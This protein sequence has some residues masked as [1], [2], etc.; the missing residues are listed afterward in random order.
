MSQDVD[1]R[2]VVDPT[3]KI[4]RGC[5]LGPFCV[6]EAG[7]ELGEGCILEPFAR[8]CRNSTLGSGVRLG[9]GAVV[10][11]LPQVT[12]IERAGGC[13]I[14]DRTRLGEYATVHS[15]AD[16]DGCT[17][18]GPDAMVMAYAHV[19][20]D[21]SIGSAVVLANGVQLAGHVGIDRGSFVGGA[22]LVHQFV[23]VGEFAFVAGGIRLDRDLAPWSRA[24]GEPARWAGTNLVGL[25]RSTQA[26]D[27]AEASAALR[28]VFRK[29]LGLDQA[30]TILTN[31]GDDASARLLVFLARS[32]RGLLRTRQ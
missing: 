9:Q 6:V 29:G 24:M 7:A 4:G 5:V 26:P 32:R 21:C 16:P 15:S 17:S 31:S 14:G 22:A 1:P 8:V 18:I 27:V 20:H 10:G 13:A 11:G 19:G 3:A 28:I 2:S 30:T 25:R 23:V 12:G